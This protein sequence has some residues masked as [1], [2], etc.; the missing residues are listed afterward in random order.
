MPVKFSLKGYRGGAASIFAANSPGSTPVACGPLPTAP[1]EQ[2]DTA[3]SSG[4]SYDPLTDRYT[5]VW[6]TDKMW[7][8]GTCRRLVVAFK[9]GASHTADFQFK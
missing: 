5:Y 6:K 4:L 3:G 8:A 9:D 7:K 1:V 2:V